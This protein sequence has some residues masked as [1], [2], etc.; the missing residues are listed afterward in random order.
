MNLR[1]WA[2][3]AFTLLM[4]ASVGIL[5]VVSVVPLAGGRQAAAPAS[6]MAVPVAIAGIAAASALAVSLLHLGHP[7]QAWLAV[8]N[9]RHS[10]LSREI[11]LALAFVLAAALFART[12]IHGAASALSLFATAA[13]V[14]TGIAVVFAMAR[15]YMIA[16]QPAWN[17]LATPAGFFATTA[18]LGLVVVLTMATPLLAP[19]AARLLGV[20]ALAILVV[21]VLLVPASL[22]A[23]AGEPSA[24]ISAASAGHAAAW[25]AAGRIVA[26]VVAA[27]LL[28]ALLRSGPGF[29]AANATR[30]AILVL[31]SLS[32]I[33]GR[34][35]FYA[36]AVRL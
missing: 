7:L 36:T 16:G 25:L 15:L 31:V 17:R 4:Q 21:Q 27:V 33:L 18:L 5:L 11:V 8:A 6:R 23:V 14:V 32:E 19:R 13:T 20:A 30:V 35:L 3:V 26:A 9:V 34:T 12:H 1:D 2:L 29:P 28:V 22:T 24:A 10:W